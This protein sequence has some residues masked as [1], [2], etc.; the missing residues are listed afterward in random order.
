[1]ETHRFLV[2]R[3]AGR[4]FALPAARVRG[5]TKASGLVLTPL[6][7]R[8]PLRYAV[9][10]DGTAVSVFVPNTALGL[11]ERPVTCRSCLLLID[12]RAEAILVDSVSRFEDVTPACIRPPSRVRLGHKWRTVLDPDQLRAIA[13]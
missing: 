10:I 12:E 1:V 7:G 6:E 2:V 11:P 4:E 3:V 9:R 8:D 5:M 13:A